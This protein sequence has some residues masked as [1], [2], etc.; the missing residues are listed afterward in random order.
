MNKKLPAY[1][2]VNRIEIY[3][4]EFEKTPKNSIKRF[5]YT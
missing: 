2:N 5:L 3:P 1:M 4:H